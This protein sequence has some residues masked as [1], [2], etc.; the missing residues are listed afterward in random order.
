M[1]FQFA[2]SALGKG[3]GFSTHHAYLA[4][5]LDLGPGSDVAA[6]AQKVKIEVTPELDT[7]YPGRWVGDITVTYT[8]G[9]TEHL[10]I[11]NPT[12]TAENPMS[13]HDLDAKFRDVTSASLGT[14]RGNTLLHAIQHGDPD[15]PASDFA[16]LLKV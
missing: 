5:Q 1:P 8:D 4:G 7:T 16:S 12:G 3:N 14:E 11:D 9:T 15:Q 10:F 2:L 13:Q 6:L